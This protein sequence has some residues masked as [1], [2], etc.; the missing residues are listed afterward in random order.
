VS[1][2]QA[3]GRY[4]RQ[5]ENS[6]FVVCQKLDRRD[7]DTRTRQVNWVFQKMPCPVV[8]KVLVK[9]AAGIQAGMVPNRK[10]EM[11]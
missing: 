8:G 5:F 2:F 1:N 11:I 10:N 3:I 7:F 4:D 6:G 9:D